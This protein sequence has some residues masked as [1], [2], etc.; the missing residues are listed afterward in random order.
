[1]G[2]KKSKTG[3]H[4]GKLNK[5]HTKVD[6]KD[7]REWFNCDGDARDSDFVVSDDSGEQSDDGADSDEMSV[8][9]ARELQTLAGG[10]G[11]GK[12]K[13]QTRTQATERPP[14]AKLQQRQSL[15]SGWA[16]ATASPST[17]S[18]VATG[19]AT[20]T[21]ALAPDPSIASPAVPVA[22]I[23]ATPPAAPPTVPDNCALCLDPIDPH[24][25]G[26]LACHTLRCQRSCATSPTSLSLRSSSSGDGRASRGSTPLS[27]ARARAVTL[28]SRQ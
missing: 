11:A 21:T 20:P 24:A 13:R 8:E 1:M 16:R 25:T 27:T 12:R 14:A 10:T 22:R 18:A 6:K 19:A 26:N 23:A 3:A 7:D 9:V 28:S 5:E 15:L 17:P 4:L 2:K